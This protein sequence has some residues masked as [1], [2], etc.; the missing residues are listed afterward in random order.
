VRAEH[1]D[2]AFGDQARPEITREVIDWDG[3]GLTPRWVG[4][5]S[6]EAVAAI[7]PSLFHDRG[8]HEWRRF[9][10]GAASRNEV[11]VAVSFVGSPG[12]REYTSIFG[13]G[14]SV[15]LPG[16][17]MSSVG[18]ER[19]VLASRPEPAPG[20]GRADRDLALRLTG[21]RPP[22]LA[23]WRLELHGTAR[24]GLRGDMVQD[25]PV[26]RLAP[27][28]VSRAGE[29]VAAVW[30]CPDEAIRH[31]VLPCLPSY[32]PVL[33][34]LAQRAVPE[35]V[36][37]AARRARASL[38]GVPQFQTSAEATAEAALTALEAGYRRR[39]ADL[40]AQSEAASA[41]ADEVRD[42][43]LYGT[44]AELEHTVAR[45]LRDAGIAVEELDDLLDGTVGAD[46]LASWGGRRLLIE[47]KSASGS[48]K[49]SLAEAPVR[50]LATWPHLR[51]GIVVSGVA[52]V[53]NHQTRTHPLDRT[54]QPYSRPEFVAS[55]T[56]PVLATTALYDWW[57]RGEHA[58]LRAAL[59]GP[60]PDGAG[61]Q[62]E[63]P[64]GADARASAGK[65]R[66]R[67]LGRLRGR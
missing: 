2:R 34:W 10:A 67:L 25:A 44:G 61:V 66:P 50:H 45:V 18:G 54:A 1:G 40:R 56:F 43:L 41:A 49:E 5:D 64:I 55:L 27:L 14:A 58:A 7:D 22:E 48:P 4:D 39:R 19:L 60:G 20:L 59:F 12:E 65:S 47:V 35:F 9:V 3:L 30:T 13:S 21:T 51:P 38:S 29:V 63:P 57:R 52:L 37:T 62:D 33:D 31:Y 8:A 15:F 42:P 24:E 26:G 6:S 16:A 32:V 53:V 28:L 36:P 17:P 11:A 23:W 46:L